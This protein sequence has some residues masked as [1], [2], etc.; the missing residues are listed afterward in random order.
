MIDDG[1]KDERLLLLHCT[2][3]AMLPYPI[4]LLP[5]IPDALSHNLRRSEIS[6]PFTFLLRTTLTIPKAVED[7]SIC[8]IDCD[9]T[10]STARAKEK[11]WARLSSRKVSPTCVLHPEPLEPGEQERKL[12]LVMMT[13]NLQRKDRLVNIRLLIAK[14]KVNL[15]LKG[16]SDAI[17][18]GEYLLKDH[19]EV[20]RSSQV[21]AECGS[22]TRAII[23]QV[24]LGNVTRVEHGVGNRMNLYIPLTYTIS[25]VIIYS[26][27]HLIQ[28]WI[29]KGTKNFII[30][31]NVSE[32]SGVFF[33]VFARARIVCPTDSPI[34][35]V[36]F[37]P[38]GQCP[39]NQLAFGAAFKCWGCVGLLLGC[40]VGS[41][42]VGLTVGLTVLGAAVGKLLNVGDSEGLEVGPF[43]GDAEGEMVGIEEGWAVG[44]AEGALVGV[45]LSL[46]SLEGTTEG[47]EL[48]FTV[49]EKLGLDVGILEGAAEGFAEGSVEGS[50]V[51]DVDGVREGTALGIVVGELVGTEDGSADGSVDGLAEGCTEGLV[52][53]D[54]DGS[55]VGLAV[56]KAEGAFVGV[57]E[58][59]AEG[60]E[61][62][63][64]EGDALGRSE[65]VV[66]GVALGAADGLLLGDID[67]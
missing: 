5:S 10:N 26:H 1:K 45:S 25:K 41:A 42:A 32:L 15:E 62:G 44:M 36:T 38:F 60:N 12:K 39:L 64:A 65:G 13:A 50:V 53:G 54:A 19:K 40:D 33:V 28:L 35:L 49:G 17:Q 46:G 2:P 57:E 55:A 20:A 18:A 21:K 27:A 56:G 63:V 11:W 14:A 7:R 59:D 29:T 48:G 6:S 67:G 16:A 31:N 22:L 47:V 51:G 8:P 61:V 9:M 3:V 43:D 58:G 23:S 37:I 52:E 24:A 34:N 30:P 66:V 4:R